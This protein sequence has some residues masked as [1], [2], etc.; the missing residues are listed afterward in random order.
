MCR[1]LQ[2]QRLAGNENSAMKTLLRKISGGLV[3]ALPITG[4]VT[5]FT[6][7]SQPAIVRASLIILCALSG[8]GVVYLWIQRVLER[9]Q[10]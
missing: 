1:S 6:W 8:V 5:H 9:L 3:L 7:E 4:S 2:V 10:K